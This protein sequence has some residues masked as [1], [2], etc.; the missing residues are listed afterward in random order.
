[1][2]GLDPAI[3]VLLCAIQ[4]RGCPAPGYAKA[5]PGLQ[6]LPGEALAKTGKA[7]HD[8]RVVLRA[9]EFLSRPQ[10]QF[11]NFQ[12]LSFHGVNVSIRHASSRSDR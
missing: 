8:E 2:A 9:S 7:G 1:M 6:Y 11:L 3:H 12:D 5:S 10:S 4:E